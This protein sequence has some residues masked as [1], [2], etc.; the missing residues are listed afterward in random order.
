MKR[1]YLLFL[2]LPGLICLA[3]CSGPHKVI[4]PK[5]ERRH[6][7]REAMR[8]IING[9][10]E[11][12]LGEPKNALVE[13][14]Q[15]AEI[16]SSS[17]GIYLA[18]AENY[19]YLEEYNSS[20]RMAKKALQR[21]EKNRDA[22][23]LLAANLEK[24]RKFSEA[25]MVYEQ[26]HTLDP[27]DIEILY[28]LTTLHIINKAY[29]KALSSYH[30][31]VDAGLAD[32]EYRLRVGHLFFQHRAFEQAKEIY[33]DVQMTDPN[34]E[35][36]YLSLAAL[37]NAE[38]DTAE[39]IRIYQNA[40]RKRSDFEEVKAE[41]RLLYEKS[42]RLD[43]AVLLYQDL[44]RR[45]STNLGDKVQLGQYLFQKRDTLAALQWFDKIIEQHPQ[46]ERGYLALGALRRAQRDTSAAIR[47]YEAAL[48]VNPLFLDA[49]RRLRD[50]YAARKRW[51]DA[52]G[53]YEALTN[54]DST[55]VGARIEIANLLVQK[56]DTLQAISLCEDLDK[57]H[58]EDWRI[59]LT[60][61]RLYLARDEN[62]KARSSFDKALTLRKDLSLIWVLAGVNLVQMD[63]LAA[64][65]EHFETAEEL[66]P[67]DPEINYFL[68]F[69]NNRQ[70]QY[71][72]A[73]HYFEKA[74]QL[75]KNNVQVMLALAAL[76]DELQ[77]NERS[78]KL[79]ETLLKDNPESAIVLNN[80]A[81][82]LAER[83][84]RLDE[85]RTMV[86]KALV[87]DPE[88]AAYWDTLGWILFQKGELHAARE[89]IEKSIELSPKSAEVWEHLGDILVL[90]GE[91][92]PAS[93]A[94]QQALDLEPEHQQARAKLNKLMPQ[95]IKH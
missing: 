2:V 36:S 62:I 79:Y 71:E 14:H 41:L 72:R 13:Y 86:E 94:Y 4:T 40:L 12:L 52:I 80:F 67:S 78:E 61:G 10:I 63:S 77:E 26:I 44:V 64:A 8:H 38:K 70:R 54:V 11:D 23:E 37:S 42:N 68:G 51:A 87:L 18:L 58:G 17:A 1:L 22:L 90:L 35:A 50:L 92:E 91:A 9:T 32:P 30:K 49:R 76:Y 55:Y 47:V 48:Q 84:L 88:N 57:T 46:S 24:Q 82:H 60:L 59:P 15:A 7:N 27:N 45:D 6:Y 34:L 81:Y 5:T 85:A 3:G 16:D 25:V 29:D 33:Q 74:Y 53:L 20:I 66:F 73:R 95:E 31:L 75:D 19:F 93:K 39:T 43:E 21:N 28:S 56:G 65:E 69:I 83:N 89:K